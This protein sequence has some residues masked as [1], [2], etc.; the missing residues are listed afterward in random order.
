MRTILP[1][2]D[3]ELHIALTIFL[4]EIF[5]ATRSVRIGISHVMPRDKRWS[6]ATKD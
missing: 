1:D 4:R 3:A 2:D 6:A 5:A